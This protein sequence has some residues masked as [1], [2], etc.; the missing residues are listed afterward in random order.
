[1]EISEI[2]PQI[3][4]FFTSISSWVTQ[5]ILDI[6]LAMGVEATQR[7]AGLI[8]F[9]IFCVILVVALKKIAIPLLKIAIVVLIVLILISYFVPS[10]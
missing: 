3:I 5:K 6:F 1:M 9:L 8:A 10:W 4:N 2:L 7:F